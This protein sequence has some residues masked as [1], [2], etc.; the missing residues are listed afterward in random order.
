MAANFEIEMSGATGLDRPIVRTIDEFVA[1][2][3][4]MVVKTAQANAY[5]AAMATATDAL[6]TAGK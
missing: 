1:T 6:G 2:L 4:A 3:K 5:Q